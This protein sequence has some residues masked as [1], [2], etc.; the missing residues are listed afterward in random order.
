V[1]RKKSPVSG[2]YFASC[3]ILGNVC[4]KNPQKGKLDDERGIPAKETGRKAAF[5][6]RFHQAAVQ[7]TE[8]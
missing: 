8:I 5:R 1:A 7:S 3:T 6:G 4:R 2:Y